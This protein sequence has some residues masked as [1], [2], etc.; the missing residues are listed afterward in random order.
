MACIVMPAM[1]C[2]ITDNSGYGVQNV[3]PGNII[4]ATYNWWGD[5]SGPGGVG[6]GTG[7]EVSSWVDYDP[8]LD[9]PVCVIEQK[10]L[11]SLKNTHFGATIF[12]GPLLLPRDKN[13]KV[14]DITGRVVTPDKIRP[15]IYFIEVE[16]K[17]IRKVVKVK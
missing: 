1:Q 8:W 6:P 15:G 7:D 9:H 11:T 5:P 14:L 4:D 3:S 12:K 10:N 17:I 2:F 16:G 13:C